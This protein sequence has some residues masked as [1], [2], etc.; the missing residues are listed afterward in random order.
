M[1]QP[2]PSKMIVPFEPV[3]G[4]NCVVLFVISTATT[5]SFLVPSKRTLPVVLDVSYFVPS[6]V[7]SNV[8]V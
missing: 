4:N 1:A 7:N 8:F 2:R 3:S 5:R 6:T